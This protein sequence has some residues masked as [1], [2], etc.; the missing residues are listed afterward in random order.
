[1]RKI[2]DR[3]EAAERQRASNRKAVAKYQENFKRV[4]CRFKPE[5][6]EQIIATGQSA[7]SFII[8]AVTEKL[9]REKAP[10]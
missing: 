7:N 9:E 3:K 4:N 8:A 5:L 10:E 2:E 6:Y 1:M